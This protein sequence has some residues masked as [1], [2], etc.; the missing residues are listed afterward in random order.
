MILK[1]HRSSLVTVPFVVLNLALTLLLTVGGAAE[2]G[3][4]MCSAAT[5]QARTTS[6]SAE[7]GTCCCCARPDKDPCSTGLK[8][9]CAVNQKILPNAALLN[10]EGLGGAPS[11]SH[12]HLS[13]SSFSDE[14]SL[15]PV[16]AQ[17]TAYLINVKFLC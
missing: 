14:K 1:P 8:G 2:A 5:E 16:F 4:K 11:P 15:E 6:Q 17:Q 13:P 10:V 3:A 9:G 7:R 12:L